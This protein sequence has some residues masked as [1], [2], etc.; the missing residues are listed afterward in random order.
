MTGEKKQPSS[1]LQSPVQVVNVGLEGFAED[2][3]RHGTPVVH[4]EWSPPARGDARLADL[5]SKLG[6]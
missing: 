1:L 6:G 3:E 5:L 4:V 2:L